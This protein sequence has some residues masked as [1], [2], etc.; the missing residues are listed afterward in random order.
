MTRQVGARGTPSHA[1]VATAV[2]PYIC[3]V[4]SELQNTRVYNSAS[5]YKHKDKKPITVLSARR[6]DRNVMDAVP[7][8]LN[9]CGKQRGDPSSVTTVRT[10]SES[11]T[12][13]ERRS[14][15]AK[16]PPRKNRAR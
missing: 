9:S 6:A 3:L 8:R 7:T 10:H 13:A 16:P 14:P 4:G 11:V 5:E 2:A 15:T 1:I 12:R